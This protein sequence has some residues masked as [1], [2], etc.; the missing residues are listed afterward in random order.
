MSD[1]NNRNNGQEDGL[2]KQK[3]FKQ[4]ESNEKKTF[5]FIHP[6]EDSS[7]PKKDEE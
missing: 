7:N 6:E 4:P 3:G 5:G 2:L 1:K